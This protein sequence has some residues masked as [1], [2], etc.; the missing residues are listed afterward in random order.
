MKYDPDYEVEPMAVTMAREVLSMY[1]T[2]L[3]LKARVEYLEQVEKEYNDFL[4]RTIAHQD[5]QA[6]NVLKLA[7][8]AVTK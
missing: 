4:S 3:H 7:L 2:N 8:Y 6:V 1:R 5:K